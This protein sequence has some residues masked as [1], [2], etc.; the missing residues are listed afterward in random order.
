MKKLILLISLFYGMNSVMAS[1]NKVFD[2]LLSQNKLIA[3]NVI[4]ILILSG[5][6]LYLFT[7]DRKIKNLENQIN[8]KS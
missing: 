8:D 2:L 3:V 7:Q 1:E 6:I 4:L 5:V